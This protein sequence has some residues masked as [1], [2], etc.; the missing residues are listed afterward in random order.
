MNYEQKKKQ[1]DNRTFFS[2][3]NKNVIKQKKKERLKTGENAE[4]FNEYMKLRGFCGRV[5]DN[6]IVF[7][8]FKHKN[9]QQIF[10]QIFFA[11]HNGIPN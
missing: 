4:T 8:L 10:Q 6:Q 9:R 2:V 5:I 1:T 7:I 3:C 11:F